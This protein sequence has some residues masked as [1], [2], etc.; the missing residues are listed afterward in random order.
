[1]PWRWRCSCNGRLGSLATLPLPTAHP[2]S[3]SLPPSLSARSDRATRHIHQSRKRRESKSNDVCRILPLAVSMA[4]RLRQLAT[5]L[6]PSI[7][8]RQRHY[9]MGAGPSTAGPVKAKVDAAIAEHV[10]TIFSKTYC[11]VRHTALTNRRRADSDSR[12][13][14]QR[15]RRLSPSRTWTMSR[16]SSAFYFQ[17]DRADDSS[18]LT[19]S[20]TAVRP[21]VP[22]ERHTC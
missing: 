9:T 4:T 11:P 15:P 20:T 12:S 6:R 2:A 1:L 18:G 22:R 8:Q 13:T 21:L 14:A 7:H 17:R 5:H 10:V 16:F 3:A 19:P